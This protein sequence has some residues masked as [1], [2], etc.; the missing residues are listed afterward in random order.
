M[1]R[2]VPDPKVGVMAVP[3]SMSYANIAGLPYVYGLYSAAIP[4]IIYG[5]LRHRHS[6]LGFWPLFEFQ[7]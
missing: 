5:L 2:V 4:A 7:I 3:Q 1:L 6:P